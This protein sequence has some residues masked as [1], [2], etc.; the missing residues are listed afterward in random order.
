MQ[1]HAGLVTD[2]VI[3]SAV[4]FQPCQHTS[5]TVRGREYQHREHGKACN[6]C[7]RQPLHLQPAKKKRGGDDQD[8]Y[9]RGTYV[10]S[11]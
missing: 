6:A 7:Q 10:F 9:Q 4:N 8:Q 3:D 5:T 11:G 2:S 1:S